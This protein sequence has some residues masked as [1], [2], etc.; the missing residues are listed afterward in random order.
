[1]DEWWVQRYYFFFES[2]FGDV[3]LA[4]LSCKIIQTTKQIGMYLL[5]SL[6]CSYFDCL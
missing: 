5:Q 6:C 4:Y 2:T 3:L 1:M